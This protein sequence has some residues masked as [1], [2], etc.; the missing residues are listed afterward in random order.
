M[1]DSYI[2]FT[3]N[4]TSVL[5]DADGIQFNGPNFICATKGGC[6]GVLPDGLTPPVPV[7]N[8]ILL[9]PLGQAG[10]PAANWTISPI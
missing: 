3:S 10:I 4:K 6:L 2:K 9:G 5:I 1:T 7:A 8:A